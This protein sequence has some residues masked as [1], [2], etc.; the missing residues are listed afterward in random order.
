[1]QRLGIKGVKFF[2]KEKIYGDLKSMGNNKGSR[3]ESPRTKVQGF[4]P[5]AEITSFAIF[6]PRV[7][8]PA[9]NSRQNEAS[10]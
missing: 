10:V 1:V 5:A 4:I 6:H 2:P 8:L 9:F 7:I 3:I